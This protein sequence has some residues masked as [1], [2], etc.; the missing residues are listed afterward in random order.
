MAG[1][2]AWRG[3]MLGRHANACECHQTYVTMVAWREFNGPAGEIELQLFNKLGLTKLGENQTW[4]S[5]LLLRPRLAP[6]SS[7]SFVVK[8]P[9]RPTLLT[10]GMRR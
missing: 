8:R 10:I 1:W 6:V 4:F 2:A 7:A 5:R 3:T 9:R